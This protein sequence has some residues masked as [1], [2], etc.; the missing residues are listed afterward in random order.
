MVS[1]E[2]G[3]GSVKFAPFEGF[4]AMLIATPLQFIWE[5]ACVYLVKIKHNQEK[6]G[7]ACKMLTFQI[8]LTIVYLYLLAQLIHD[9]YEIIYHG[10]PGLMFTTLLYSL[11][12]DNLKSSVTLSIVYCV[13]VRRFMHLDINENEYM[14]PN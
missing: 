11:F 14:D 9:I 2:L 5:L 7:E 13:V 1:N 3:W 6:A 8:I 12:L 10:R 4:I